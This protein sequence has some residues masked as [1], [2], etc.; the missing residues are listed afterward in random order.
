VETAEEKAERKTAESMGMTV[1][2]YRE[3]MQRK[4]A[5]EVMGEELRQDTDAD[6]NRKIRNLNNL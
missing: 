3:H 1:E 4:K 6:K 2:E 5:T